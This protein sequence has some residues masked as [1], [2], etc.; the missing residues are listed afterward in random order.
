MD[1][2]HHQGG[3][4]RYAIAGETLD[5]ITSAMDTRHRAHG[6]LAHRYGVPARVR[7]RDGVHQDTREHAA[8][9]R[10]HTGGFGGTEQRTQQPEG[11]RRVHMNRTPPRSST[12]SKLMAMPAPRPRTQARAPASPNSSA[13]VNSTPNGA[14]RGSALATRSA[15]TTPDAL[16]SAPADLAPTVLAATGSATSTLT[17]PTHGHAAGTPRPASCARASPLAT[18]HAATIP[19]IPTARKPMGTGCDLESR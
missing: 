8:R 4:A 10:W 6:S 9:A 19:T 17:A 5:R 14:L 13:L 2:V 11:A 1:S 7:E 12:P 18:I 3:D 15:L 16:S